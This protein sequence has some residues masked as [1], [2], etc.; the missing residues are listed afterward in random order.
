M[1]F[2][3]LQLFRPDLEISSESLYETSRVLLTGTQAYGPV[4]EDSDYDVVMR[5][6][7]AQ[8]L[9]N[10]LMILKVDV[11]LTNDIEPTYKG[12]F[13][14]LN[15]LKKVQIIV[16]NTE[17]EFTTWKKA[18]KAMK[19]IDAIP[20]RQDRLEHFQKLFKRILSTI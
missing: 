16:T 2:D 3:C 4:A 19:E 5:E 8:G 20:D 11:T 9:Y 15:E 10:L 18:T 14:K 17:R 6:T 7:D 12:F 1:D 13:F